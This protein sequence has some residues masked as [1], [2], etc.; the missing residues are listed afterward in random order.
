MARSRQAVAALVA[1]ALAPGTGCS[2]IFVSKPP[3][4][5]IPVT[6][7]LACTTS[8]ASPVLDTVFAAAA[9]GLGVGGIVAGT[10]PE[11]ACA[12]PDWCFQGLFSGL[13]AGVAVAGGVLIAT[14]IPLAFSAA[15]GY[16]TTAECRQLTEIQL[17]CVSGVEAS[18]RRLTIE[19]HAPRSAAQDVG[20]PCITQEDC[21]AGSRCEPGS[22]S[23]SRC[24]G[25]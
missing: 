1:L 2:W 24:V 7:P 4:A 13:N 16:S 18:C 20:T 8:V 10:Q 3:P 5:P 12:S 14:A 11:P 21:T 25:R 9:L 19:T 17:A 15:Y 22:G 23:Q 6:P